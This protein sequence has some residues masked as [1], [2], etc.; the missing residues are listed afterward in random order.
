MTRYDQKFIIPSES[1]DVI[2]GYLQKSYHVLK[3]N[4]SW[5]QEYE[6]HYYDTARLDLARDHLRGKRPR[7]KL[8]KR[9]YIDTEDC[10]WEMKCKVVGG[11][12]VKKRI[13]ASMNGAERFINGFEIPIGIEALRNSLKNNYFRA[14]FYSL[15]SNEKVTIDQSLK[16]LQDNQWVDILEG[17]VVVEVKGMHFNE[18]SFVQFLRSHSFRSIKFSKYC[19]GIGMLHT[20]FFPHKRKAVLHYLKSLK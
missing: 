16:I 13:K 1:L 19:F 11:Q 5:L 6:N 4:E 10:Y 7:Y 2:L 17:F 9:I 20:Q 18:S 14:S 8:R 15:E 12:M 3:V